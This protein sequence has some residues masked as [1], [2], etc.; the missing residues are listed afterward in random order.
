MDT[1]RLITACLMIL[2]AKLLQAHPPPS[3]DALAVSSP[4]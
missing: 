3:P 2:T 4:S 1:L